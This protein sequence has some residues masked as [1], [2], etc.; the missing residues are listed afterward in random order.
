M[1]VEYFARPVVEHVLDCR[2]PRQPLISGVNAT[3]PGLIRANTDRLVDKWAAHA[4]EN[5]GPAKRLTPPELR[6]SARQLFAAIAD[7]MEFMQT[8]AQVGLGAVVCQ[9]CRLRNWR[10]K[11]GK[12]EGSFVEKAPFGQRI[13]RSLVADAALHEM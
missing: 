10:E 3:L 6:D 11:M 2:A 7:D 4:L 9:P 12:G 13:Q 1:E 8:P 5:I